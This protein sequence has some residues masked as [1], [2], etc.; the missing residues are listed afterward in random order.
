MHRGYVKLWRASV[1]NPMY[2]AEPFTRW[3]AWNDLILMANHKDS[4]VVLRGIP[5][6]VGRGQIMAGEDFLAKRWKWSR[7]K[8][9]RF[10]SYLSSKTVQQIVQQKS[11]VI[12]VISIVNYELYQGNSTTD[13]TTVEPSDGT[14]NG[15]QTVQQTD[16]PKNVKKVKNDKKPKEES[17]KE[18]YGEFRNV[19]LTEVEYSKLTDKFGEAIALDWIERA[20]MHFSSKGDKYKSHYAT[21]LNW[22]RRKQDESGVKPVLPLPEK[23]CEE[24]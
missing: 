24:I 22:D 1:D 14:T 23:E 11:R 19:L 15:Q 20:S 18:K 8:V 3:Q 9:R 7:G 21:I 5:V 17:I 10:M 13:D 16:I 12:T 4:M 6:R 2:F